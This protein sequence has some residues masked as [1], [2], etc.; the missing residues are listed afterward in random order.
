MSTGENLG[1]NKFDNMTD[2]EVLDIATA[3]NMGKELA[4]EAERE[5]NRRESMKVEPVM[6]I[7]EALSEPTDENNEQTDEYDPYLDDESASRVKIRRRHENFGEHAY[8]V[9]DRMKSEKREPHFDKRQ[10]D[11]LETMAHYA[12][13]EANGLQEKA[14]H[15]YTDAEILSDAEKQ[16]RNHVDDF[17]VSGLMADFRSGNSIPNHQSI[18]K[19]QYDSLLDRRAYTYGL[20]EEDETRLQQIKNNVKTEVVGKL[21]KE[22]T[23]EDINELEKA[24]LLS[25]IVQGVKTEEDEFGNKTFEY[26]IPD[27]FSPKGPRIDRFEKRYGATK[28]IAPELFIK[29]RGI[30]L[31]DPKVQNASFH[32]F[33][34]IAKA[35]SQTE[36]PDNSKLDWYFNT[37]DY[38]DTKTMSRLL[39]SVETNRSVDDNTRQYIINYL[40]QKQEY[41]QYLEYLNSDEVVAEEQEELGGVIENIELESGDEALQRLCEELGLDFNVVAQLGINVLPDGIFTET[42]PFGVNRGNTVQKLGEDTTRS[43]DDTIDGLKKVFDPKE[44]EKVIAKRGKNPVTGETLDD[45]G[46]KHID[47]SYA[48]RKKVYMLMLFMKIREIDPNAEIG[49]PGKKTIDSNGN[50]KILGDRDYLIIRFGCESTHTNADGEA[51]TEPMNHVIAE[52]TTVYGATYMWYGHGDDWKHELHG[53]KTKALTYPN[54]SRKTHDPKESLLY[55][56]NATLYQLGIPLDKIIPHSA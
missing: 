40:E 27:G 16:L 28:G 54:V 37:F 9:G 41:Q 10:P 24:A 20:D 44:Y 11:S 42:E 43:Y 48:D 3:P 33:E 14:E 26:S 29:N 34:E 21:F 52:S 8:R 23:E 15:E 5:I 32:G 55:H 31:F 2:D 1:S 36:E 13:T 46:S 30:D 53:S 19:K 49:F 51:V 47:E 17:M 38:A 25:L 6:A 4:E 35:L 12:E 18:L 39:A 22:K 45:Y 7:A 50:E 56:H